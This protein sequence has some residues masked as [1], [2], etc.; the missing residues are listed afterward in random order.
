MTDPIQSLCKHEMV[1]E[2]C[3]TC[4]GIKSAEEEAALESEDFDRM[5]ERWNK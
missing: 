3:A 4:R 5:L 2:W 1:P